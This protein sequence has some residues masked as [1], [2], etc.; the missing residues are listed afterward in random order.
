MNSTTSHPSSNWQLQ[1]AK[2]Q[3]SAVVRQAQARGPQHI[4]VHGKPA[5]VVVSQSEYRRL[6]SLS[7]KPSFTE[8]MQGSPWVGLELNVERD[9]DLT[10]HI[11]LEQ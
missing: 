8:L 5:V 3:F 1:D 9:A 11:S 6:Q 7:N 4:S 10:R 2:A